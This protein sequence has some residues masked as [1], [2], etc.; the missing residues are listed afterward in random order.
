MVDKK[1]TKTFKIWLRNAMFDDVL[2]ILVRDVGGSLTQNLVH[3][4][5]VYGYRGYNVTDGAAHLIK[6][7][8]ENIEILRVSF[9][10]VCA[11]EGLSIGELELCAL[12]AFDA[13]WA[14][15]ENEDGRPIDTEM[16]SFEIEK[17]TTRRPE[18]EEDQSQCDGPCD[19]PS[20]CDLEPEDCPAK[21]SFSPSSGDLE[22]PTE[23]PRKSAYT[24]SPA[25]YLDINGERF[26]AASSIM[27]SNAK[28][29]IEDLLDELAEW[30]MGL[31]ELV[32]MSALE[33]FELGVNAR[34]SRT[35]IGD[36][37]VKLDI[38]MLLA[39]A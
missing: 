12:D 2:G 6:G 22:P 3:T 26:Y 8:D 29:T 18:E 16:E 31:G 5:F 7:L 25:K 23:K 30:D 13:G 11:D 9:N 19:D 37:P 38:D 17:C 34:R 14:A 15:A 39:K 32:E 20:D 36:E 10:R 21:V 27:P 1:I 4:S 35:N 33:I 28:V 24:P